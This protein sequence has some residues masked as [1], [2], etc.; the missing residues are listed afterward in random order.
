MS[1]SFLS[2]NCLA[3]L[4][5]AEATLVAAH[6]NFKA[7]SSMYGTARPADAVYRAAHDAY[8]DAL[9]ACKKARNDAHEEV[10]YG[11]SA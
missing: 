9:D 8:C 11:R 5:N 7:V 10:Y 4:Q 6:D 2:P 3:R 1:R